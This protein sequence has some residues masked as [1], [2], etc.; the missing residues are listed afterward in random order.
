[1]TALSDFSEQD[2]EL[3][4]SLPYRVGLNVSYADDEDGEQDDERE[5]AALEACLT[6]VVHKS[7]GLT[8]EVAEKT[9]AMNDKWES[10]GQGVF[11]IEPLCE[12]ASA[13][14][15]RVAGKDVAKDYVK[16]VL[17]VASA[18]AQAYGEFG[19]EEEPKGFFG[20]A[21]TRII[22]GYGSSD[23]PNHPMNISAAE[24]SAISRISAALKSHI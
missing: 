18:V 2:V 11:N 9:L 7:E 5:M 24:D 13:A 16:M 21:M 19:E 1:M 3:I 15:L 6:A 23:E 17:E 8:K 20:K 12:Q 22:S 4:V 14:V 10:W